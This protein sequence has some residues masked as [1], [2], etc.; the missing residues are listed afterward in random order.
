MFI[1]TRFFDDG[2]AEA[3]LCKTR[4]AADPGADRDEYAYYVE[5]ADDLQEWIKDNL[6]IE[7]DDIVPLVLALDAGDWVS[8]TDYV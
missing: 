3:R 2:S 6:Y 7:L 4:P 1:E 8:I 5:E